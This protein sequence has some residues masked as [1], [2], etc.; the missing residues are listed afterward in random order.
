VSLYAIELGAWCA[1]SVKRVIGPMLFSDTNSEG[2]GGK[3]IVHFLNFSS[4]IE[5]GFFQQGGATTQSVSSSVPTLHNI[6]WDR[7]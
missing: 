2:H 4:K 5:C 7:I 6:F 1:V 3:I